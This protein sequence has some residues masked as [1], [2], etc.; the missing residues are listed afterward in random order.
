MEKYSESLLPTTPSVILNYVGVAGNANKKQTQTCPPAYSLP[1]ISPFPSLDLTSSKKEDS[2]AGADGAYFSTRKDSF[3]VCVDRR[4]GRRQEEANQHS[5]E[6]GGK[7]TL[8][9]ST[10]RSEDSLV[11]CRKE[12]SAAQVDA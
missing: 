4:T 6:R 5:E 2:D 9:S 7:A 8:T 10:N 1:G 11:V 3:V 12:T